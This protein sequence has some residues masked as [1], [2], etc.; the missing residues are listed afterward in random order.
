[1]KNL[2]DDLKATL[3]QLSTRERAEL[4]HLLISS[5]DD[6]IDAD[7]EAEWDKEL[8][9]RVKEIEEGKAVGRP[10]FEVLDE[11]REKDR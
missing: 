9:R 2:G 4:A 10:A 8:V 6:T 7:A 1:M 3:L 5:L 11:I